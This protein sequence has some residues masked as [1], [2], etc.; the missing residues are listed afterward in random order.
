VVIDG[1][2]RLRDGARVNVRSGARAASQEPAPS[3]AADQGQ[4]Q[5][6]RRA[7][8]AGGEPQPAASPAP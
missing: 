3:D 4:R 7:Q 5:H 2:D 8:G 6:R 1:V